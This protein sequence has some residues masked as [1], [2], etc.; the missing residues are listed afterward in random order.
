MGGGPGGGFCNTGDGA[1]LCPGNGEGG[2]TR[3]AAGVRVR[4]RFGSMGGSFQFS[5]VFL[6]GGGGRSVTRESVGFVD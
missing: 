5:L 6:G 3:G 1:G 2:F 4:T